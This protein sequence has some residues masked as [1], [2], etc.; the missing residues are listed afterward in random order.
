MSWSGYFDIE[1][2]L[3][4]LEGGLLKFVAQGWGIIPRGLIQWGAN[5]GIYGTETFFIFH[6]IKTFA[7]LS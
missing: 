3:G 7:R 4:L 2:P 6:D 1:N 5:S